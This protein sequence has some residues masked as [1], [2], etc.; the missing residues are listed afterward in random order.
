MSSGVLTKED[1]KP[2]SNYHFHLLSNLFSAKFCRTFE[3]TSKKK[4]KRKIKTACKSF[5]EMYGIVATNNKESDMGL[6][7][8]EILVIVLLVLVLFGTKKI[9]E[10]FPIPGEK[11]ESLFQYRSEIL[12]VVFPEAVGNIF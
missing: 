5:F 9:P 4:K 10:S 1:G 11:L 2:R 8:T 7:T 3:I 12:P 6:S